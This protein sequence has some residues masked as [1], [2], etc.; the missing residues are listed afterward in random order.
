[1]RTHGAGFPVP[2]HRGMVVCI[3]LLRGQ[4]FP[5]KIGNCIFYPFLSF[6]VFFILFFLKGQRRK[7]CGNVSLHTKI[8]SNQALPWRSIRLDYPPTPTHKPTISLPPPLIPS[9]L[10]SSPAHTKSPNSLMAKSTLRTT[11]YRGLQ[12]KIGPL[13]DDT[14]HEEWNYSLPNWFLMAD[15]SWLMAQQCIQR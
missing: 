3:F 5:L 14:Y 10:P 7:K 11:T 15:G 4:L 6:I 9:P 13:I 8:K 2:H 1:M 12:S